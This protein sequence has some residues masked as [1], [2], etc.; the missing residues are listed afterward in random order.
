[1][2]EV[3]NPGLPLIGIT[4]RWRLLLRGIESDEVIVIE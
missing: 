4:L 3:F 2:R 1:V